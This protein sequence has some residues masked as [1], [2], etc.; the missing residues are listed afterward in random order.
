MFLPGEYDSFTWY[1]RGPLESYADRKLSQ[2]VGLYSGTVDEQHTPYIVP[3][4]NG[5]KTDV[6]WAALMDDEG[7]GLL[8]MGQPLLNVSAHHFTARDLTRAKHT[9]ELQPRDEVILSLD[10]AQSGLGNESCGPG[11]LPQYL[12]EAD[13]YR[14][15]LRLRPFSAQ[16]DSPLEL[17]KQVLPE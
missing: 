3:Q 4:E 5:N 9:H 7:L 6:R 16:E 11:V 12:L 2:D 14:Y 1:G 8:V 15:S 17:S 10:Y 13:E